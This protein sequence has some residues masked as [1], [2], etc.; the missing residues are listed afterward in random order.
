MVKLW[1]RR[2]SNFL[3]PF[4]Y[5]QYR[6]LWCMLP[7]WYTSWERDIF[8]LDFITAFSLS[9]LTFYFLNFST[10]WVQ[11]GYGFPAVTIWLQVNLNLSILLK[12]IIYL[13]KIQSKGSHAVTAWLHHALTAWDPGPFKTYVYS[14]HEL[15]W[16]DMTSAY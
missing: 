10:P 11:D 1:C 5:K 13:I 7:S 4:F 3:T 15:F 14:T 6:K 16:S 12:Y 2:W 9:P 8:L